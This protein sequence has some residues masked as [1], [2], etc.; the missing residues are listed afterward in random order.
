M[1]TKNG[2]S[3]A[4][5]TYKK[6]IEKLLPLS[7]K[8]K[9]LLVNA[10]EQKTAVHVAFPRPTEAT[11]NSRVRG[12]FLRLLAYRNHP[13]FK[14]DSVDLSCAWIT[15]C[16]DLSR[17]EAKSMNFVNCVFEQAP[18][19]M[20]TRITGTFIFHGCEFPG[21]RGDRVVCEG[22]VFLN[23][24][25]ATQEVRFLGARISHELDCNGSTMV[26]ICGDGMAVGGNVNLGQGFRSKGPVRFIGA[27]VDGLFRLNGAKLDGVGSS[28][29][30]LDNCRIRGSL[31]LDDGFEAKGMV[32]L[33]GAIID[34]SIQAGG[35][36]FDGAGA[37]A[38]VADGVEVR[39]NCL[40]RKI[41]SHGVV[42]FLGA[43]IQGDMNLNG[44][45]L[46]G[47]EG[48]AFSADRAVVGGDL[49]LSNGF[50]SV[51]AVRLPFADIGA[52]FDCH[53]STFTN[54]SDYAIE[55]FSAKI[56]GNIILSEDTIVNGGVV[57][58]HTSVGGSVHFSGGSF[59]AT[60][61]RSILAEGLQV[62]GTLVFKDLQ[63]AADNV[64]FAH[65]SVVRHK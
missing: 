62:N 38:L 46:T 50:A 40:L 7:R 65:A 9:E 49:S 16:L 1:N 42:R 36:R 5:D 47:L 56:K 18:V 17:S 20:D 3:P 11:D 14:V 35:A 4:P 31:H 2:D 61:R 53:A 51:G 6:A 55:C 8:E 21:L 64:S 13:H 59:L 29:L 39:G 52:N 63:H 48:I 26:A 41:V 23:N 45:Q 32:V 43:R 24:C 15:G 58:S 19:L 22:A 27:Q 30:Q 12:E 44:A 57:L 25:S 33:N 28:A 60:S 54:E 37:P 10:L 34:G